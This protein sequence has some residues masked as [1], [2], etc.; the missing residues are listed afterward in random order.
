MH[1][2]F[3]NNIPN[4]VKLWSG[5]YKGLDTGSEDYEIPEDV[6][7]TIWQETA[8][9]VQHLPADFVRVLGGN[10]SYYT[11]EAWCFWFVYLAPILLEGRFP[12]PK[13]HAHLCQFSDIIK[14]C[15]RF[16]VKVDEVHALRE[17]I[18]DWVQKYEECV[19]ICRRKLCFSTCFRYY[20]QYSDDRLCACPL[21]IHGLIHTPD[22][23]LF[24]GPSWTTW[25]FFVERY[26][27]VLQ[28]RLRSRS[29][30]WANLNNIILQKAY[31]EQLR[32]RYDIEEELSLVKRAKGAFN[33]ASD[34]QAILRLPFNQR[35]MP[36]QGL[37][38]LVA[39][40]FSEFLGKKPSD[41][42]ALLPEIMPSYGKVRIVDGDSIRSASACGD[43][44]RAERNMSFIRY[45]IQMRRTQ[46]DIWKAQICYGRLERILVCN[47]P[48]NRILG[49]IA[50]KKRLLAVVTPCKHTQGKDGSKE[51][52]R[53]RG[54]GTSI[55]IDLQSVVAVIARIQSGGSW[56]IVDRTG[57]FIRPEFIPDDQ[58][59]ED[60]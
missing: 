56:A 60:E 39:K 33:T 29:A 11:A 28:S 46:S 34:P 50:G 15:L 4:L 44:S 41:L 19:A 53:D 7:A 14:F 17:N 21:T 58:D 54:M 8:D 51:I 55:I 30:P 32:A 25:T 59:G 35:Y 26:C 38:K 31:L 16:T 5:N 9:A 52:T 47:L 2:F 12:N 13:Y 22:D 37:R 45:E 36:D 40:Y 49:S 3:E 6:W 42:V 1:L 23:I 27:G 57:G 43:G 24:C 48:K 20:Y 10:P 18:I